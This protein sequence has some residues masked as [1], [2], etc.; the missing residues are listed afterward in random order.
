M[1]SHLLP[2]E[3]GVIQNEK[4][5]QWLRSKRYSERTINTY[6]DALKSFFIFFLIIKLLLT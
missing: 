5:K 4:F 1:A 6:K 2:N 3:E